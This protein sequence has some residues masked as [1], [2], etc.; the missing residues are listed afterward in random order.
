MPKISIHTERLEHIHFNADGAKPQPEYSQLDLDPFI[1]IA[2]NCPN[3]NR[4]THIFTF[5]K[6]LQ[7]LQIE[8]LVS[9]I[10]S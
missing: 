6:G 4:K 3:T 2:Y 10:V 8:C 9:I 5:S 7:T 1:I